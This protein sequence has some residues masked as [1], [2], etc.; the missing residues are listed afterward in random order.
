ML[1]TEDSSTFWN[2][3]WS[4]LDILFIY[5]E[6]E[7]VKAKKLPDEGESDY[8]VEEPKKRFDIEQFEKTQAFNGDL[9]LCK[10]L[11]YCIFT[12]WLKELD[13]ITKSFEKFKVQNLLDNTN[14][15]FDTTPAYMQEIKLNSAGQSSMKGAV[16]RNS[17]QIG[18]VYDHIDA[19]LLNNLFKQYPNM[20]T[21]SVSQEKLIELR[22][23][24][25]K[26][27][28]NLK[29]LDLNGNPFVLVDGKDPV[30]QTEV[31][32]L[33]MLDMT[34]VKST[35]MSKIKSKVDSNEDRT[36]GDINLKTDSS[37]N[38]AITVLGGVTGVKLTEENC[39]NLPNFGITLT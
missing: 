22:Q 25:E 5:Q 21:T 10:W 17:I 24:V 20:F 28:S 39:S 16:R 14:K 18:L 12:Q 30:L 4:K 6:K 35:D 8:E 7:E 36:P 13:G 33:N 34:P 38:L 26:Q 2:S 3:F 19:T 29:I 1:K 9:N 32:S 23:S 31:P 27:Y 15:A 37:F 11:K